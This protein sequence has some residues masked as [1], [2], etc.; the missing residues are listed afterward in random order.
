[1]KHGMTYW[2]ELL[3]LLAIAAG[4]WGIYLWRCWDCRRRDRGAR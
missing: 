1:M 2:L 4:V 3:A